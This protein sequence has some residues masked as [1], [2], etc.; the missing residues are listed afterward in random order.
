MSTRI[1]EAD[2]PNVL[3]TMVTTT[4][5]GTWLPG[6]LRG[7]VYDGVILP[8]NPNLL[9][10][11]KTM[12]AKAP[13]LFNDAQRIV[14][15]VVIRQ[16]C[17][18]FKYTMLDLSIDSWHL[19]WIV[20]HGFDGVHTMVGRLKT[21]MRQMVSPKG[22]GRIWTEGY[23]HRCLYTHDEIDVASQYIAR[24]AGCRMTAGVRIERPSR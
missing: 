3:A 12:L 17:D 19:H 4:T 16:A 7:Y 8:A 22:N 10:H 9:N 21:R 14:L 2:C 15:D 13:V 24:H 18:E 23:C 5:Y 1:R 11:A 20:Q 6:D